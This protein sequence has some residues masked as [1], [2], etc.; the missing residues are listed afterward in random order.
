M[1]QSRKLTGGVRRRPVPRWRGQSVAG[2]AVALTLAAGAM[3]AR[4]DSA[5]EAPAVE[6]A[7]TTAAVAPV[8][9]PAPTGA[10]AAMMAKPAEPKPAP[11]PSEQQRRMLMLLLMNSAGPLRTYGTLG[12]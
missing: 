1:A 4:S 6:G 9:T 5:H 12:R 11:T 10:A 2:L 3:P 7:G 8:A